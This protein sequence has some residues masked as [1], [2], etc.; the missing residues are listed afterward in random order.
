MA[1]VCAHVFR[2]PLNIVKFFGTRIIPIVTITSGIHHL[3]NY[4]FDV[5]GARF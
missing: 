4:I 1:R 5:I 2:K 3:F